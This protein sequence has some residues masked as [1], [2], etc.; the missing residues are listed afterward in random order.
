MVEEAVHGALDP[1]VL[2]LGVLDR[3]V[4]TDRGLAVPGERTHPDQ[5]D[6]AQEVLEMVD[7]TERLIL[8]LPPGKVTVLLGRNGV[9]RST[10]CKAI[11]GLVEP[12]GEVIW[13][14]QSLAGRRADVIARAGIGYVPE[15]RRIFPNLTVLDNLSMIPAALIPLGALIVTEGILRRHAPSP[16][17]I[18]ILAGDYGVEQRTMLEGGV[19]RDGKTIFE[20]IALND[21]IVS[22]GATTGMVELRIALK[23]PWRVGA[24]VR[25]M[26]VR[27]EAATG[28]DAASAVGG[29]PAGGSTPTSWRIGISVSPNLSN[30]SRDA[31]T[32]T[33]RIESSGPKQDW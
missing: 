16:A 20:S 3:V 14:G 31:Q 9:G 25:E 18:A 21:V 4:V 30:C 12:V 10:T 11:M 27:I 7:P 26:R 22:R 19:E 1:L 8:E 5:V 13:K 6:D 24:P 17:K 23:D 15:E 33:T 2:A 29:P 32:S 28:R